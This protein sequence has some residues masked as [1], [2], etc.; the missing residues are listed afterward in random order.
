MLS[1]ARGRG[2]TLDTY[3]SSGHTPESA[4]EGEGSI[5][6]WLGKVALTRS[7]EFES[8]VGASR[9]PDG[10]CVS[11]VLLRTAKETLELRKQINAGAPPPPDED[12]TLRVHKI[13][14]RQTRTLAYLSKVA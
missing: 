5:P 7:W 12:Q 3:L 6:R 9:L 2:T 10:R 14:N 11:L 8:H 4:L 1:H 13:A